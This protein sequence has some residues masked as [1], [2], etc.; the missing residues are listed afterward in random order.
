MKKSKTI[1]AIC[2]SASFYRD[3]LTIQEELKKLGFSV[4]IPSTANKMRRSSDFDVTHYK[5]W[6][7]NAG[8]YHKKKKLMDD[9]FKKILKSDAILVVNKEKNG[10]KGYIGGNVLMEMTVAYLNKKKIYVLHNVDSTLS[11]EEEVKGMNSIFINGDLEK[12]K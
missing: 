8:D 10:I 5:T 7:G 11:L 4:K 3:V 6:Y 12:I 1:I 2:S 9:H